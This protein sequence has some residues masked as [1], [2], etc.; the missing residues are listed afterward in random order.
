MNNG[1]RRFGTV[2]PSIYSHLPS[3]PEP[4]RLF[5]STPRLRARSA[6]RLARCISESIMASRHLGI[7]LWSPIQGQLGTREIMNADSR[8]GFT[9]SGAPVQKEMRG[10]TF[11]ITPARHTES[12]SLFPSHYFNF[13]DLLPCCKEMKNKCCPF[14]GPPF[15]GP[16]VRP[17]VLNMPKSASTVSDVVGWTV[18][19]R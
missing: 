19:Y 2:R 7:F 10:L 3:R 6:C 16:P 13:S 4:F 17:N 9:P 1:Y 18:V 15:V 5:G 11:P 12:F 8:V 14:V